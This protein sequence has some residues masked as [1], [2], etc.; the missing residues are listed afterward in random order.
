[1]LYFLVGKRLTD[2]LSESFTR[3]PNKDE[4]QQD[5][6]WFLMLRWR[7]IASSSHILLVVYRRLEVSEE[8]IVLM[9]WGHGSLGSNVRYNTVCIASQRPYSIVCNSFSPCG[10]ISLGLHS[11]RAD[12]PVVL[13]PMSPHVS[14][15]TFQDDGFEVYSS[16][17][18]SHRPRS[19]TLPH[20]STVVDIHSQDMIMREN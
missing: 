12:K 10:K 7:A 18:A 16:G 19:I 1:M 3:K 14:M 5:A 4:W 20:L 2:Q 8:N 13:K 6:P 9:N 15:I 17:L 11:C